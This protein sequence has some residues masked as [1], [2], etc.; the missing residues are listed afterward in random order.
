MVDRDELQCWPDLA[1]DIE[2]SFG[3]L[4]LYSSLVQIEDWIVFILLVLL[5]VVIGISD[6]I[7]SCKSKILQMTF[8]VA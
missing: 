4:H 6:K 5:I 8:R 2:R 3:M 1:T 7:K